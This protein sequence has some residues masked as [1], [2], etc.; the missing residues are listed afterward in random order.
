VGKIKEKWLVLGANGQLGK[1]ISQNLLRANLDFDAFGSELDITKREDLG[2]VL[3]KNKYDF[4]INCA[5]WTDVPGAEI[6]PERAKAVNAFGPKYIGECLAGSST[7]FITFSTDYVFNGKNKRI[8]KVSDPKDPIN[9]YG[10]SK[11]LGEDLV[12]E[13]NLPRFY[14]LRTSWLYSAW[15]KNFAL[16]ILEKL[17]K[18]NQIIKVVNDQFGNPTSAIDL[19]AFTRAIAL[20]STPNG[21]YHATNS[22]EASWFSFAQKI[23]EL[24]AFDLDRISPITSDQFASIVERPLFSALQ[25]TSLEKYGVPDMRNWES[26]LVEL[27]PQLVRALD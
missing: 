7:C 21:I 26:A 25:F 19:A 12:I 17:K 4:V 20:S 1:A 24:S 2:Q 8:W 18:N 6:H 3:K 23:C 14:I 10:K 22:A 9:H 13:L 11:A 5:A 27:Y 15:N 16:T